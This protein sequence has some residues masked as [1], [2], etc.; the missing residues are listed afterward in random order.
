MIEK[1]RQHDQ[2]EN[3]GVVPETGEPDKTAYQYRHDQIETHIA[4]VVLQPLFVLSQTPLSKIIILAS[5]T[6]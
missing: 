1:L 6:R 4:I 2:G 3:Q 5:I